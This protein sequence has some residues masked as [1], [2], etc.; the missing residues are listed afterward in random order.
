MVE[1]HIDE[2]VGN[3][4]IVLRPNASWMWRANLYLLG[5]L[6]AL[7]L[8]IGIGFLIMGAWVILPFSVVELV[9]VTSCFYYC[10]RQCRLQQI[11]SFS[12]DQVVVEHGLSAPTD[13]TEFSRTWAK[14][15]VMPP[16][17]P[18]WRR[19]VIIRSHGSEKEL[20]GFLN[21]SDREQ[22]VSY[23]RKTVACRDRA[24]SE[25]PSASR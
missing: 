25:A 7:S 11:I 19:R 22:L 24:M 20:G 1:A 10:V 15:L 12:G 14:F 23:L 18:S 3:G 21:E 2:T 6:T 5:V 17:H 9:I 13:V 8:S 16:E 4:R